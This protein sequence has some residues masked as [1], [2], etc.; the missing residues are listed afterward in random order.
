MNPW[1]L[2]ARSVALRFY[3]GSNN[4]RWNFEKKNSAW[5]RLLECLITFEIMIC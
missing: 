5:G 3:R 4:G 2:Q 1:G